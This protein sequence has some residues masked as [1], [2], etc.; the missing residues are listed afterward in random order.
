MTNKDILK[1]VETL[2]IIKNSLT[3]EEFENIVFL[4]GKSIERE[5]DNFK[6]AKF[7]RLIF[8]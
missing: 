8:K 4:I 2:K 6:I 1:I 7:E 3:V 5:N